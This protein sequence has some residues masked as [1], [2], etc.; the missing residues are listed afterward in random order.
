MGM[1]MHMLFIL[2]LWYYPHFIDEETKS[3]GDIPKGLQHQMGNWDLPVLTHLPVLLQPIS[4]MYE[5]TV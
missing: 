4:A 5:C 2:I 1:L 3:Q